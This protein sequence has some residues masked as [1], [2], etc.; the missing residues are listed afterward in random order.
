[1]RIFFAGLLL[2]VLGVMGIPVGVSAQVSSGQTCECWCGV[3]GQ[4]ASL[5]DSGT[6]S[7]AACQAKC[8]EEKQQFVMCARKEDRTSPYGNLRCWSEDQCTAAQGVLDLV[9]PAECPEGF[10]FCYSKDP[11][12]P[13]AI[14]FGSTKTV[15]GLSGY[16]AVVYKWLVGSAAVFA[17]VVMMIGGIQYMLAGGSAQGVSQAKEKITNALTG[18]VLLLAT[19]LILYTVNPQLVSLRVPPFPRVRPIVLADGQA[20]EALYAS[21]V[22]LE[23]RQGGVVHQKD[24]RNDGRPTSTYSCGEDATITHDAG[25]SPT[26]QDQMCVYTYC[27]DVPGTS[28]RVA[29]ELKDSKCVPC[30]GM[31]TDENWQTVPSVALCNS[32]PTTEG[33]ECRYFEEG[34]GR[35]YCGRLQV[36]CKQITKCSDYGTIPVVTSSG[37]TDLATM[38]D[39]SS[40]SFQVFREMCEGV[41]GGRCGVNAAR[42]GCKIDEV[43]QDDGTVFT[44]CVDAGS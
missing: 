7:V 13:L 5:K 10:S 18:M 12:I 31:V 27:G 26:N 15:T 1:M 6:V 25:G 38:S 19:Y 29:K 24:G 17:V 35:R 11:E 40:A 3:K 36:D 44:R 14:A 9:R 28:C 23:M 2:C 34:L 42:G 20:C 41:S 22:T 32:V 43:H 21:G 33:S 16:L 30:E 37:S 8:Q 4:G 39:N